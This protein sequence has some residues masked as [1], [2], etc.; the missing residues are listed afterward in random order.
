MAKTDK[1]ELL[2]AFEDATRELAAAEERARAEA[3]EIV[4]DANKKYQEALAALQ[5]RALGAK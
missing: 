2:K 5:Q 3:A 1:D 4:R